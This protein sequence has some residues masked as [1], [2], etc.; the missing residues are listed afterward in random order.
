MD[1]DQES[2][3]QP[4]QDLVNY[5]ESPHEQFQS[6]DDEEED[7]EVFSIEQMIEDVK[8]SHKQQKEILTNHFF[9]LT[10]D[11]KNLINENIRI[12]EQLLFKAMIDEGLIQTQEQ[13]FGDTLSEEYLD[14]L[15][16]NYLILQKNKAESLE[17]LQKHKT[18]RKLM[19][20]SLE[21]ET[22]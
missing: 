22:N 1:I 12:K 15:H 16:Q 6:H 17:M 11:E 18:N 7:Y 9:E 20:L 3:V 14:S 19:Q 21:N 8:E 4:N 2:Q 10:E 5:H 13:Y